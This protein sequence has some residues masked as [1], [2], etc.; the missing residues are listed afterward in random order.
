MASLL[1]SCP[2]DEDGVSAPCFGHLGW[3]SRQK[4]SGGWEKRVL[5]PDWPCN[6][7]EIHISL[8]GPQFPHLSPSSRRYCEHKMTG[9]CLKS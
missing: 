4:G 5:A 9:K 2:W 8:F 3:L 7:Q 6:P 1:G